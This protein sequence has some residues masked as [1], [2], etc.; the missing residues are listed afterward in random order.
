MFIVYGVRGNIVE[1]SYHKK[2][3]CKSCK[4]ETEFSII[5]RAKYF[6]IF[7]I[8]I[9]PSGKDVKLQCNKCKKVY[10][11]DQPTI[12][13]SAIIKS[14]ETPFFYWTGSF[15]FIFFGFFLYL[16]PLMGF[17]ASKQKINLKVED[18]YVFKISKEF[19]LRKISKIE[20]DS[21]F[22]FS[23]NY[24]TEEVDELKTRDKKENFIDKKFGLKLNEFLSMIGERKVF[25]LRNFFWF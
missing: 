22:F 10:D 5:V 23:D 25:L 2:Q 14:A 7:W 20:K 8:P 12:E 6:H 15:A 18:T 21:V 11:S 17:S 24:K 3:L 4:C 16:L 19:S 13:Y 1:K 9:L